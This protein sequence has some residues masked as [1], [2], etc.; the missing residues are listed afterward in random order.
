MTQAVLI[1]KKDGGRRP[2]TEEHKAKISAGLIEHW[3]DPDARAKLSAALTGKLRS[4]ETREK[5]SVSKMGE[6]HPN[7]GKLL[8]EETRAK[9]RAYWTPER[10]TKKS[11]AMG[12]KNNP[13]KRLEVRIKFRGKNNPMKRPEVRV[14]ISGQNNPAKRPEVRVKNSASTIEQW[15]DSE[16][17]D[18]MTGKSSPNW[19][20][21]ISFEPYCPQFNNPLREQYR[22][23]YGRVCAYCDKPEILNGHR[24]SVHHVDGNKNQGC[25]GHDWFLVPLCRSCNSKG[26]ERKP[27]YVFLFWLKDIER[28]HRSGH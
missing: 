4:K 3:K 16:F 22:N 11:E 25:D 1:H 10:R 7:F 14:K 18:R 17:R 8:S 26:F 21:G 15:K 24:L 19:R 9:Q 12:G 20:G 2:L 28:K 23:A 13:M 6:N 27:E 5:I